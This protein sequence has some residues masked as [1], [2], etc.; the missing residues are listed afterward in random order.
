MFRGKKNC[1]SATK[2][3]QH[4]TNLIHVCRCLGVKIFFGKHKRHVSSAVQKGECKPG[5]LFQQGVV[6]TATAAALGQVITETWLITTILCTS[7][8]ILAWITLL[9]VISSPFHL[10]MSCFILSVARI[11]IS[12][13]CE[14]WLLLS[15]SD[16]YCTSLQSHIISEEAGKHNCSHFPPGIWEYRG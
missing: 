3:R 12:Q 8:R 7:A 10:L 1:T 6:H 5:Q 16:C 11:N 4:R 15:S 2:K 9:G 13:L 14:L